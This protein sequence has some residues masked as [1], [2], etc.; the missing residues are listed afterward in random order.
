MF[1]VGKMDLPLQLQTAYQD[2]LQHHAAEPTLS[3]DGS[4]LSRSKSGG[5]YWFTRKRDGDRLIE[6][7]LGPDSPELQARIE[8]AKREQERHKAWSRTAAANVA[9]L[10]AGRCLAPDMQTGRL[11]SA[12]A[13]TGFFEAGGMLGGTQAFRHYPLMLGV[14]A[15]S[16][17]FALTGD[18]DLLAS[19]AVRLAGEGPG[20]ASRIQEIGIEMETVF[21]LYDDH[22]PKWRIGGTLELEF[23]SPVGSGGGSSHHH[24]GIGER[25]Q[26]IRFLEY[27]L[28]DPA[29]AVS[30]YRS[31]VKVRVPAPERYALHKLIVAQLRDGPYREKRTKDFGQAEWLIGVLAECRPYELW[32]ALDNLLRRGPKWRRLLKLSVEER[33]AIADRLQAIEEE[34]GP[35]G[36]GA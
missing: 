5:V 13:R 22:P 17:S 27:S 3:I 32:A 36:D 10:R 34:F 23:L 31:G 33:P 16:I 25:V 7:A 19:R 9:V 2:L 29:T 11:L 8:Q 24:P 1:C 6:T 20:L 14:D 15:P 21:G 4:I 18:V 28:D 26:A 12:I 30:L 35:A